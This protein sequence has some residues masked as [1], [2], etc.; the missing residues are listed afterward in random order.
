MYRRTKK[1]A[2]NFLVLLGLIS[3]LPGIHA[4]EKSQTGGPFAPIQPPPKQTRLGMNFN[5]LADWNTELPLVDVFHEARAWISQQEGAAWGKGPALDLDAQGWIKSLAPGAHAMTCLL[6]IPDEHAP[7]GLYTVL[8][9]GEGEITFRQ[10][11]AVESGPGRIVIEVGK[12][13]NVWLEIRQTNPANYIRNIRVIRPGFE[14]NYATQVFDPGFLERWKGVTC[15]R[16]LGW[17]DTNGSTLS[18]WEDRPKLDDA[19]WT[20]K[21]KG[22]PVEVMVDLCNRQ[23]ADAWFLM[24]HMAD[25]D[26][27]ENFARLVKERLDPRLRVYVEYSNEV[28]NG[29]FEQ[30]RYAAAKGKELGLGDADKPWVGAGLYHVRRSMEIMKIWE[31]AFGGTE[32]LVRVLAW[33]A[34]GPWWLNNILLTSDEQ[35]ASFDAYAIAP[36]LALMPTATSSPSSAEVAGWTADQ[37]LDHLEGVVF[38]EVVNVLRTTAEAATRHGLALITYEGGQHLL[39]PGAE[40]KN[41]QLVEVLRS[42]NAHPRMGEIY[43]KYYAAWQ[44]AGGGLFCPWISTGD[45]TVHGSWGLLRFADQKPDDVAKCRATLDW[46]KSLGQQVGTWR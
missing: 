24:P 9:D 44:E 8:Y 43:K 14:A 22:V 37:V 16:F 31:R 28:W 41:A 35:N 17:M 13:G 5:Q 42:A 2:V 39:A 36:Y 26:F 11:T 18:K 27:V 29:S 38:P 3:M 20:K 46:A 12:K 10:A 33:Q 7:A 30:N 32:R 34:T 19:I 15:I 40:N 1:N 45:W 4:G 21:G 6:T 25:D 23:L